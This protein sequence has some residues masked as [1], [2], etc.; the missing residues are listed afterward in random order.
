MQG[1]EITEARP[2]SEVRTTRASSLVPYCWYGMKRWIVPCIYFHPGVVPCKMWTWTA[3]RFSDGSL[4]GARDGFLERTC[5]C[6]RS[7]PQNGS[8]PPFL[9]IRAAQDDHFKVGW[10]LGRCRLSTVAD[11]PATFSFFLMLLMGHEVLRVLLMPTMLTAL[12]MRMML[13]MVR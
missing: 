9:T 3:P 8:A 1:V 11:H 2:S 6:L 4:N 10:L 5:G 13:G 12:I 7:Y